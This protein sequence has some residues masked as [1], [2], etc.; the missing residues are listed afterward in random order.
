M[1]KFIINGGKK[2]KGQYVVSG[3]KNAG[4]KLL[5]ASLLSKEECIFH[6]IPRISDTFKSISAII[7]LGGSAK[8]IDKNII[9]LNCKN[10][11][12]SEIPLEAMSARQSV[13]FIGA[14]LARM[15][16]IL[17]YAPKGDAIGKRPIDRHLEG[18]KAIGGKIRQK[19]NNRI[20][21]SMKRRPS[22]TTYTFEKNT[23]SGTENLILASVF[24]KGKIILKNSAL[25]PEVDN[26]IECL[27]KMGAKIKRKENRIIEIIGVKPF[28]KKTKI[29]SIPDRLETA[30]ALVLSAMNNGNI[31]VK[32][33]NRNLIEK[34]IEVFDEIGIEVK[35]KN[36]IAKITKIKKQLKP[37]RII[38]GSHPEFITDWQPLIT[39][40][41]SNLSKG[42]STIYEMIFEKRWK[43]LEELKKIGVKYKLF[44][45]KNFKPEDYNFNKEEYDKKGKYGAYIYGPTKFKP[46]ELFSHDVRAGIDV[47]LAGLVAKGKTIINDP[48]NH[49]DRGYEN[50]VEKL[51]NLGADIRRI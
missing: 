26:L 43:Y 19:D 40:L 39:L 10:I 8:F 29:S 41:L 42:K 24:N 46:A 12:S 3:A 36:N 35:F 11:H 16:K 49:I 17:I 50:I 45:P 48:M 37:V 7:S 34:F 30:T 15:G 6:N 44:H 33:A 20:E 27:N 38:T 1:S 47:L 31:S 2:L 22:S 21:I 28:L 51:N 25:E 14:I 18:I 23:H 13:L 9:S 32:N 4:P 5:I